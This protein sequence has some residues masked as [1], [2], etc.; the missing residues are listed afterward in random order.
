MA[1]HAENEPGNARYMVI[2]ILIT[3]LIVGGIYFLIRNKNTNTETTSTKTTVAQ[4]KKENTI[5]KFKEELV[6]NGIK[7]NEETQKSASLIGAKEGYAFEINGQAIEVYEFDE[8]STE[9]LTKDNIKS[10]KNSGT[11][12]M[13]TFNNMT[14]NVKYNNGLCLVNYENH[15][16]KEKIIEI[17]NNL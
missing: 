9:E 12:S 7:I 6:N 16:D 11:I 5:E 13:P 8:K 17:F 15:S 1:K 4:T 10:A 2:F 3:L 14:L